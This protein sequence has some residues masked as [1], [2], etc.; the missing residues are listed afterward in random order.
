MFTGIVE[1]VC[2][3]V[4]VSPIDGGKRLRVASEAISSV[5]G[6]LTPWHDLAI[7]ESISV[8]GVCLTLVESSDFLAFDVVEESLRRT[9]LGDRQPGDPVNLER[10][11][12]LGDRLGGHYVTG[13]IDTLGRIQSIEGQQETI[14]MVEHDRSASFRTVE[15]GS[16]TVDGVSLT[17][18]QSHADAF[19]VALI[20]HTLEVTTFATKQVGDAVNLEMDH[21][22][23]WVQNLSEERR[24]ISS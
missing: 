12:R 6:D 17:V 9:C 11:L 10:A 24:G 3:I 13:H 2:R 7:G 22:G 20:P 5:S 21:F 1:R 18:V 4:E 14:W 16:V 19:S 15:K 8:D 23:R